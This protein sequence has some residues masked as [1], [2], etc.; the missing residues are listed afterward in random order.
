MSRIPSLTGAIAIAV[1]ITAPVTALA[2]V[3]IQRAS[4]RRPQPTLVAEYGIHN[5]PARPPL[6]RT[7]AGPPTGPV[8]LTNVDPVPPENPHAPPTPPYGIRRQ[9]P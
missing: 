9:V 4:H 8:R 7:H 6:W 2:T 1:A 3:A 5:V